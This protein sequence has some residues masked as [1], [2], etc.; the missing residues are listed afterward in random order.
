LKHK[1]LLRQPVRSEILAARSTKNW[2]DFVN[3]GTKWGTEEER[4][5]RIRRYLMVG[6]AIDALEDVPIQ[7]E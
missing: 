2:K 4:S 1:K 6:R 3:T 5:K 7:E